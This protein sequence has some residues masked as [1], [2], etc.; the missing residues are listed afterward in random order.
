MLHAARRIGR[1]INTLSATRLPVG[2][3]RLALGFASRPCDRFALVEDAEAAGLAE[4]SVNTSI[5]VLET[6]V[7]SAACQIAGFNN[8]ENFSATGAFGE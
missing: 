8:F 5:S 6:Y 3:T 4:T 7:N 2:R 1:P